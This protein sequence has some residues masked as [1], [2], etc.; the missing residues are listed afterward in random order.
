MNVISIENGRAGIRWIKVKE[1]VPDDRRPVLAWGTADP[2]FGHWHRLPR[3]LGVTRF[4]AKADGGTFDG[5]R[6]HEWS[7]FIRKVTHWAEITGPA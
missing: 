5:E 3:F 7:F 2:I 6:L 4:N 1:R